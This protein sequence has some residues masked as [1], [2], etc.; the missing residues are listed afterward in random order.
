MS[1]IGFWHGCRK[2]TYLNNIN[3]GVSAIG[4]AYRRGTGVVSSWIVPFIAMSYYSKANYDAGDASI[5]FNGN[6][7]AKADINA[8]FGMANA[9]VSCVFLRNWTNHMLA[10]TV[11]RDLLPGLPP[12][13]QSTSTLAPGFSETKPFYGCSLDGSTGSLI[14]VYIENITGLASTCD[15]SITINGSSVDSRTVSFAVTTYTHYYTVTV[16]DLGSGISG[17]AAIDVTIKNTSSGARQFGAGV[18]GD[19][20]Y[21]GANRAGVINSQYPAVRLA[22][23]DPVSWDAC[24]FAGARYRSGSATTSGTGTTYV[25]YSAASSSNLTTGDQLAYNISN[26]AP[27][28]AWSTTTGTHN[29]DVDEL[30]TKWT[31]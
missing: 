18:R 7:L 1:T 12:L 16:G 9:S 22:V 23:L 20:Y 28:G 2:R 17:L 31:S 8:G 15:I 29:F 14:N 21:T 19:T 6:T 4:A 10:G 24:D 5:S 11:F 13:R 3:S 25:G 26:L 27:L 30:C